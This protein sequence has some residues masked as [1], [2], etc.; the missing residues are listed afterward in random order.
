MKTENGSAQ[1][2]HPKFLWG[3]KAVLAVA[4]I[5]IA[6]SATSQPQS[7][8]AVVGAL[9]SLLVGQKGYCGQMTR[10]STESQTKILVDAGERTWLHAKISYGFRN[11]CRGDFSFIPAVGKSYIVRL[12][13]CTVEL[14]VFE[15]GGN[16][17]PDDQVQIEEIRSC[18]FD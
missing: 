16:P 9:D 4:A 1:S 7:A 8:L 2:R 15:P 3:A 10:I 17:Q 6:N 12:K 13:P 18:L 5:L 14:F 11:S